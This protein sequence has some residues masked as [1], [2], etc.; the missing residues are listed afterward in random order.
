MGIKTYPVD[1]WVDRDGVVRKVGVKLEYKLPTGE[2]VQMKLSEE[3]Y[4]FGVEANIEPP[5]AKRVL[6]VTPRSKSD[7]HAPRRL[8]S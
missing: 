1:L 8:N 4:D 7:D 5:P 2:Y 6:D 3:Y